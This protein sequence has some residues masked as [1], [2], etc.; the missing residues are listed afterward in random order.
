MSAK[1]EK[2]RRRRGKKGR[3]LSDTSPATTTTTVPKKL[4]T[5]KTFDDAT[6]SKFTGSAENNT[7]LSSST[8]YSN[9]SKFTFHPH[10]SLLLVLDEDAPYWYDIGQQTKDRNATIYTNQSN[11]KS[12]PKPAP[13]ELVA[14]YR[15]LADQMYQHELKLYQQNNAATSDDKW[16]E[17]TMK[18]GTLKDRVAAMSVTASQSPI[19]K[20]GAGL[21]QLLHLATQAKTSS[22]QQRVNQLAGE[23]LVDLFTETYL[24]PHRKL[25]TLSSRPLLECY[26]STQTLSPRVLLLW[27]LEELIKERYSS[28]LQLLTK[29]CSTET[30]GGNSNAEIST[31][32][33]MTGSTSELQKIMGIKTAAHLLSQR[34]EGE[35]SLLSMVVNKIGDPH[36]KTAAAAGHALRNVLDQ[37][38]VMISVVAR[39]VM[40]LAHRPHLSPKAMYNCIIFLNQ[41]KL[42]ASTQKL[43]SELIQTYFRLFEVAVK[44]QHQ[45]KEDSKKNRKN[46]DKSNNNVKDEQT[47]VLKSRL[48]SALLTG[49]NRAHPF[50]PASESLQDKE[51]IDALY[52]IAHLT[53]SPGTATQSLTLLYHLAI[54]V[55]EDSSSTTPATDQD[56]EVVISQ[57]PSEKSPS[58]SSSL[59]KD[60]FYRTL[61]STL[62]S[63]TMLCQGGTKHHQTLF[64]NLLYK[65]MKR[66]T[67]PIRV[68]AFAKRLL[69][70]VMHASENAC[71]VLTASLF[72]LSEVARSQPILKQFHNVIVGNHTDSQKEGN[73]EFDP[74]KRD[75]L[76]AFG[77][78]KDATL[79]SSNGNENT[80][81]VWEVGIMNHHF[82]P[83]V[84][85]FAECFMDN[86]RGNVIDYSGDPLR[87][88]SLMPF[89]DRF[90]YRHPKSRKSTTNK[91]KKDRE[92]DEEGGEKRPSTTINV[93]KKRNMLVSTIVP[94]NDEKFWNGTGKKVA[95]ENEFFQ[96]FFVER[97]RRDAVKGIV[98]GTGALED[99]EAD[100]DGVIEANENKELGI[101]QK[102][103]ISFFSFEKPKWDRFSFEE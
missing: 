49:V 82:H 61:Y 26:N 12:K 45:D 40:Q 71:G 75:P 50:L 66:D 32:M 65:S 22:Q 28:F 42:G 79:L 6:T 78:D 13:A 76:V 36:K 96:K 41:L 48:L 24:P 9:S 97:A 99:P 31:I 15:N 54:G 94:V 86:S 17:N 55:S 51:R 2:P 68:L 25:Y 4:N 63:P 77:D 19:H 80:K 67:K 89:L 83:S 92:D 29:W 64:F 1:E 70:T 59:R 34:P 52:R 98:R 5:H 16:V 14:L 8:T 91:D 11:S 27:R 81:T 10:Q 95:V 7:T 73:G 90:A 60:R 58:S 23:A 53:A 30:G 62:A 43:A 35:E 44:Q 20:M 101:T 33:N 93:M 85:K 87:D 37:H 46:K 69:H 84:R 57:N 39:E 3:N 72:L 18:R 56:A 74:S 47:N 102:V 38:P 100:L 103:R 21:D 88:F